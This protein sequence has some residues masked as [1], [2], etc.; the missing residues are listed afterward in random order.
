MRS[1]NTTVCR[2]F[3]VGGRRGGRWLFAHCLGRPAPPHARAGGRWDPRPHKFPGS[4]PGPPLPVVIGSGA[5]PFPF[6][7]RKLS[8]IPPMVLHAKVCGRVGRCRH[9]SL[10]TRPRTSVRGRVCCTAT[11]A[12]PRT[13]RPGGPAPAERRSRRIDRFAVGYLEKRPVAGGAS[14]RGSR[15]PSPKSNSGC[16]RYRAT[17]T[18]RLV[19]TELMERTVP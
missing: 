14:A 6:R 9:Y 4:S 5:H 17:R 3:S 7:T 19:F 15:P 18:F 2:I 16:A 13:A 11:R 1:G 10:E 12:G 8:L